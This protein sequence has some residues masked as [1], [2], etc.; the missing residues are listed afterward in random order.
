MC[1][2]GKT[3][4]TAAVVTC[5]L[6]GAAL[7]ADPVLT[8]RTLL[9]GDAAIGPA[10]GV[11]YSPH[12]ALGDGQYLAVWT[13]A[14]SQNYALQ[15]SEEI[16]AARIDLNG[17]VLDAT[18]IV[19]ATGWGYQRSARAAW[20]GENW[21]VV[22]IDYEN[23]TNHAFARRVS[24]DGVLLDAE[25]IA[26]SRDANVN[27]FAVVGGAGGWLVVTES[28]DIVGMRVSAAGEPLDPAGVTLVP[29]TYYV[30]YS[31]DV[32]FGGTQY[33]LVYD[34]SGAVKARRF[35]LNLAPI[36]ST[37]NATAQGN[38]AR[39]TSNGTD[40]LVV[41]RYTWW[42]VFDRVQFCRVN[43]AG[44]VLDPT[45]RV[46][47]DDA[48]GPAVRAVWDGAQWI[49]GWSGAGA[50]AARVATNGTILDPDGVA[51][52]AGRINTSYSIEFAPNPEGGAQLVWSDQRATETDIFTQPVS[53]DLSEGAEA[54]VSLGA[55]SQVHPDVARANDE[56][57]L[58][59]L[60]RTNAAARV[61]GLRLDAH[62]TPI[63]AEPFEI[64]ASASAGPT[65]AWNGSVFLVTWLDGVDVL[66]RR[67]SADG[68]ILDAEPLWLDA[69]SQTVP[70]VAALG[71]TF[72]VVYV[73]SPSY[74][75][76][77]YPHAVRVT[78]DGAILDTNPI[79]AGYSFATTAAVTTL[80]ERWLI[81]CQQNWSHNSTL[82]S[83]V[84]TF[85]NAAGGVDSIVGF[86]P[87]VP[88]GYQPVA[89]AAPDDTALI[90]WRSSSPSVAWND[91]EARR[92]AA[93]GTFVGPAP[94]ILSNAAEWQLTPAVTHTGAEYFAAWEDRRAT[95]V[96]YYDSRTDIYATRVSDAGEILDPSGLAIEASVAPEA[97][98]TLAG[99]GDG[100]ALIASAV[101]LDSE[102]GGYR[103]GVRVLNP[104]TPPVTPGDVDGDGD[105]DLSDLGT[106]LAAY[107][108]CTGDAGY[109]AAADFDAG[110]CIDL[111]DLGVLLAS[112]GT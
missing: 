40:F 16:Y 44:Q 50:W 34:D 9:P 82:A 2:F 75:E 111:S 45:P 3:R 62:G 54:V 86:N 58:V 89:V 101:F 22:W 59:Y 13:D 47:T 108:T 52:G 30:R 93:D 24:P 11:Q 92:V 57:L 55:P 76:N 10:A 46:I 43:A 42:Y 79:A 17:N 31:L 36:G 83:G 107:G 64:G 38:S 29:S 77:R 49:V 60:S 91:I 73:N 87:Y 67:V 53:A 112:Y 28:G 61:M 106:L 105:V 99:S 18:P 74:W 35:D 56:Y 71:D 12:L 41:S 48:Y 98:V 66:A 8:E 37:F 63:D 51:I 26:V 7:G 84:M 14:R 95:E 85:I 5:W 81:T 65:V 23:Y 97:D 19:V 1:R 25:P 70:D 103:I 68:A 6:C 100:G 69:A 94:L 39:V 27:T 104:P 88:S 21:L 72:L 33:L 4:R 90:V 110:G 80:G 96:S 78:G 20:D 109:V 15:N 32:A 102:F